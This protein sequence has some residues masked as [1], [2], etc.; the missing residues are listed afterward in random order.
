MRGRTGGAAPARRAGVATVE[1]VILEAD[2]A[3][4]VAQL[5]QELCDRLYKAKQR[6]GNLVVGSVKRD[7]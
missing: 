5:Y 1:G 4:R 2:V 6:G 3:A 7:A